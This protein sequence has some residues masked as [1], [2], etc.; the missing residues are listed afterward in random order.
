M[1]YYVC[2]GCSD[3]V[4]GSCQACSKCCQ[5]CD[6]TCEKLC[7]GLGAICASLCLPC[8][9]IWSRPLGMYVV[10][11][12]GFNIPTAIISV[13]FFV[14]ADDCMA[15]NLPA[16]FLTNV[17]L[18]C[19]HMGFA[20]YFQTRLVRGLEKAEQELQ[21]PPAK[22]LIKR[23]WDVIL[24]D[25]GFLFYIFV[26]VGS[27][28]FNCYASGWPLFCGEGFW[29]FLPGLFMILFFLGAIEFALL[30]FCVLQ[31][32]GCFTDCCGS[33]PTLMRIVLGRRSPPQVQTTPTVVGHPVVQ[34]SMPQANAAQALYV[35]AQP[36]P[37]AQPASR[38]PAPPVQAT[39]V[40]EPSK[41]GP[42]AA[43]QATQVAG[44]AMDLGKAGLK[45]V[46]GWL[47]K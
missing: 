46:G 6:A 9:V 7:T 37:S 23:A 5:G 14:E 42:T 8:A 47:R 35:P 31:C 40:E 10:L 3:C 26:F 21:N 15:R 34:Q 24:Y 12:C 20:L 11:C 4:D 39:L 29:G 25:F 16:F 27:F 2:K 36:G 32:T 1:M 45:K 38:A 13:Y 28:G 19:L 41:P 33:S 44:A 17:V 18:S 22:E 43:Q 30:W